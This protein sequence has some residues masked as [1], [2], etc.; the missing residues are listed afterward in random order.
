MSTPRPDSSR[1]S[2]EVERRAPRPALLGVLALC[3]LA[4]G[5]RLF[6]VGHGMPRSYLPDTH[7]VRSALGMAAERSP[8]PEI[9]AYSTYP[10]LV[11]YLL[12]PVYGAY[13]AKGRLAGEWSGTE[14]FKA[15]VVEHPEGVHLLAR[16]L[17]A[18]FGALTPLVIFL[19]GR[20]LGLRSRAWAAAWLVATGVMHVHFS[21]QERPWVPMVFFTALAALPAARHVKEP[22]TG[23]LVWSGV[24]AALAGACHQSGLFALGIPGLAWLVAPLGWSGRALLERGKQGVLC[25]ATFAVLALLVGYPAYLVHGMPAAEQTIGGDVADATFGGQ[26]IDF[27]RRWETFPRLAKALFG[28]APALL[29]LAL[30]GLVPFLRRRAALP[31]GL[32][33]VGWAAFFMTHS[34]DHVRYLLPLV[35]LLALP[36][37]TFVERCW[38]S[39]GAGVRVG[40]ALALLV[41]LVLSLRLGVVLDRADTR[42]A[43]EAALIDRF[44]GGGAVVAID[45]LGP[46]PLL[47]RAALLRLRAMREAT[48][49]VLYTREAARLARLEAGEPDGGID[50]LFVEDLCETDE[51]AGTI[52]VRP[53]L[54][55]REDETPAEA[56]GRLGVTHLLLVNRLGE[57]TDGS[58]LASAVAGREP[59]ETWSPYLGSGAG[60]E[61]RLPMELDFP[62]V[63]LWELEHPGPWL[64]LYP[65]R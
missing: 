21:V 13:Y 40:L 5:V 16:L 65:L 31:V 7:V 22:R 26:S 32:F 37:G 61:S 23:T 39:R 33:A 25:V 27:Y 3:L 30:A 15:Q 48:G 36:A 19:V 50:V 60:V 41:P 55:A 54:R 52:R 24:C 53:A 11:P 34:N 44:R 4:L 63:T 43:A 56:L 58:L 64:G 29:V 47:D 35:V 49:G 57:G 8:V 45:R 9:G 1:P 12:L 14:E 51:R 2:D 6:A 42:S 18:V 38:S 59:V 46:R 62:L 17:V 10:N 20:E 28:H